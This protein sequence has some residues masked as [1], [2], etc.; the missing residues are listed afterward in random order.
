M[1]KV[2]ITPISSGTT[3]D[4][5]ED[6]GDA[7]A[8]RR[9]DVVGLAVREGMALLYFLHLTTQRIGA[10]EAVGHDPRT[11]VV[12]TTSGREVWADTD[13]VEL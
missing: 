12:W 10:F 1:G 13:C 3:N 4:G 7:A 9:I 6:D 8:A 5:C 11:W 2:D